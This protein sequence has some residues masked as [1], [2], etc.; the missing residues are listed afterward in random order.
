VINSLL[1]LLALLIIAWHTPFNLHFASN[2]AKALLKLNALSRQGTDDGAQKL[3]CMHLNMLKN[4]GLH[5]LTWHN[6]AA[7][8]S[9]KDCEGQAAANKMK[10]D[11]QRLD[12]CWAAMQL[13]RV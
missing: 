13:V 8:S 9:M 5:Q 12:S 11:M 4:S 3:C 7:G 6:Y 1:L 10:P 2:F